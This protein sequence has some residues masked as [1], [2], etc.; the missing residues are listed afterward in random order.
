MIYADLIGKSFADGGRG[1]DAY[2]CFGL[3][4]ELCK[5]RGLA[6]PAEPN[7]IGVEQK[8][9]AIQAAIGRGEWV[10]IITPEPFCAVVFRM[11]PPF[12]SH[13]GMVLD[14]G[15]FIH[16]RRGANVAIER[17]DSVVWRSRIAGYYAHA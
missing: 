2:D 8:D 1:P 4:E 7:P 9:A 13:I 5:R 14:G 12:V 16:I 15:R 6:L 17:L 3:F 10:K 11:I